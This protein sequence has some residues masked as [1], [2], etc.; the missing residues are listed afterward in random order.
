MNERTWNPLTTQKLT[1]ALKNVSFLFLELQV[2]NVRRFLQRPMLQHR[3]RRLIPFAEH[4]TPIKTSDVGVD[5]VIDVV[6]IRVDVQ[7]LSQLRR[8]DGKAHP[9]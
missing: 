8:L 6:G 9:A 2:S 7:K 5:D 4:V 3:R 1:P